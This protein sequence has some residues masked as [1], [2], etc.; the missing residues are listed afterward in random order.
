MS[1]PGATFYRIAAFA[2]LPSAATTLAPI[3]A[4]DFSPS[5]ADLPHHMALVEHPVHRFRAWVYLAHPFLVFAAVLG[6]ATTWHRR[7]PG[8]TTVGIASFALWAATEAARQ[9]LTLFAFDRWR[10]LWIAGDVALRE[11][12]TIGA[13]VYDG[14]LDAAYVLLIIGFFIGN[15]CLAIALASGRGLDLAVALLLLLA[16]LLTGTISI[17]E[18]GGPSLLTGALGD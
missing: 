10:R 14:L 15:L 12:M 4:R 13:A 8:L 1:L 9:C 2:S 18:F 6:L 3:F 17:V 7:R 11:T 16:A 5:P